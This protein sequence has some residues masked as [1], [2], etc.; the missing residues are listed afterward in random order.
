[1]NI[2]LQKQRG[3][4]LA[5][6]LVGVVLAVLLG[7]GIY[8]SKNHG[9][10]AALA[11]TADTP[12]ATTSEQKEPDTNQP[13]TSSASQ[14]NTSDAQ[15]QQQSQPQQNTQ[16]SNNQRSTQPAPNSVA[17]TGPST[18]ASTGPTDGVVAIV[19]LTALTAGVSTYRR[20]LTRMR[21]A[22]LRQQL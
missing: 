12:P 17:S 4:I 11:P 15:N 16:N 2:Q 9:R 14:N 10:Q 3:G 18:I 5:F 6:V 1:M 20:S 19:A 22:A 7:G 21:S 8:L 13:D